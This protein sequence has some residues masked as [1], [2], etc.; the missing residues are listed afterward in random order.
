MFFYTLS[1]VCCFLDPA[2]TSNHVAVNLMGVRRNFS[3]GG[4]SRHFAYPFQVVDDATQMDVHKTL[5]PFY[6]T[7]KIPNATATVAYSV[8]ALQKFTL[9]KCLFLLSMDIL[10]VT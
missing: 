8:F 2:K 5:H 4:Q 10:R 1:F 7:K 6:T 3:R 9:R